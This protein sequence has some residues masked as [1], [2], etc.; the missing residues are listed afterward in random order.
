MFKKNKV[1]KFLLLMFITINLIFSALLWNIDTSILREHNLIQ[2]LKFNILFL[3]MFFL[4]NIDTYKLYH[5]ILILF[6]FI[7]I[8]F[9]VFIL[10]N[11]Y[12]F[13]MF[14]FYIL[15]VILL[16]VPDYIFGMSNI[17]IYIFRTG[18]YIE[19][20][21]VFFN[22]IIKDRFVYN[23]IFF[24]QIIFPISYFVIMKQKIKIS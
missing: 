7:N 22:E 4:K 23:I 10:K 18:N 5:I 17:I 13:L 14:L 21:N 19:S 12:N 20:F 24:L 16:M 6:I 2:K 15:L 1:F 8:L 3:N 11:K 9:L